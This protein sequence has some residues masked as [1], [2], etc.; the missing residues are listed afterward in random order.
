MNGFVILIAIIGL[1][2]CICAAMG[3]DAESKKEQQQAKLPAVFSTLLSQ[4][5]PPFASD[6]TF[7]ACQGVATWL[8]SLGA[9]FSIAKF[10][11]ASGEADPRHSRALGLA[12]AEKV[13]PAFSQAFAQHMQDNPEESAVRFMRAFNTA[14]VMAKG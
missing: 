4:E 2:V 5:F 6:F 13:A 9:L 3:S 14:K 11:T 12:L 8:D 7:S 1:G 10:L